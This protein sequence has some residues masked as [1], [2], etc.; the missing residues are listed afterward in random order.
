VANGSLLISEYL[1]SAKSTMELR[2]RYQERDRLQ[3]LY[4]NTVVLGASYAKNDV[5]YDSGSRLAMRY[6]RDYSIPR[7]VIYDEENC[8][9]NPKYNLNRQIISEDSSMYVVSWKKIPVSVS[10]ILLLKPSIKKQLVQQSL[11]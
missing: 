2:G 10:D 3:A 5:G 7:V 4:S 1:T 8:S 9:N 11:I 6:A